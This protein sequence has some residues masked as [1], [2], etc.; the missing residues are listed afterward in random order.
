MA[1]PLAVLAFIAS[2]PAALISGM[3]SVAQS[4]VDPSD[5]QVVGLVFAPVSALASLLSYSALLAGG[6]PFVLAIVRGRKPPF[7]EVFAVKRFFVPVLLGFLLLWVATTI[8]FL[9]CIVPGV[10][11]ALGLQFGFHLIVDRGMPPVDALKESWRL[12]QGHKGNLFVLALLLF[13]VQIAGVLACCIGA[14]LV[15]LP[16]ILLANA[17]VY[18]TLIGEQPRQPA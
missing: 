4:V 2:L 15:S 16:I 5:V 6:V 14:L 17:Y 7:A 12:T 10:I 9:L 3:Q 11:L 8:G 13:G 18:L 1:V